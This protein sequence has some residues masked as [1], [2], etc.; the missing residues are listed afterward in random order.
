MRLLIYSDLHLEFPDALRCFRVP[1][2][3]DFDA[4]LLAG[5]IHKQDDGI[6]W[7][8][9]N[10]AFKGKRIIY[11]MGNH[12]AYHAHLTELIEEM[13]RSAR[14]LGVIFLEGDEY[15]DHDYG[16]RFLGATLWTDFA[17]YGAEKAQACMQEAARCMPDFKIIRTGT[18]LAGHQDDGAT[19]APRAL[20]PQDTAEFFQRSTS[21]FE[22]KLAEPFGGKTVVVSHHLPSYA[23]VAKRYRNDPVPAKNTIENPDFRD[24]FVVDI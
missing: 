12:E 24:D 6:V 3:L 15:I 14:E 21:W 16:I 9:A 22:R 7:A 8:A 20:E 4:V 13:R 18:S 2:G 1:D 11:V 23:L 17:L 5:D 10:E 19:Q